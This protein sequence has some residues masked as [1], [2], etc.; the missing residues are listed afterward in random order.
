MRFWVDEIPLSPTAGNPVEE[1]RPNAPVMPWDVSRTP[2]TP[3]RRERG[4]SSHDAAERVRRECP[5]F[6]G[7]V[8]YH[9]NE[10]LQRERIPM[11]GT[12]NDRRERAFPTPKE[13]LP[14]RI[15][16]SRTPPEDQ[17]PRGCSL[18]SMEPLRE[19]FCKGADMTS[20]AEY[21]AALC[22]LED[23]P[24]D[25]RQYNVNIR[26]ERWTNFSL[27]GVRFPAM[28]VDVIQRGEA[29]AI[30]E[31]DLIIHFQQIS[32]AAALYI[33]A[34][35][36]GI[37]RALEVY[38]RVD[39]TTKNFPWSV[40]TTEEKW[41]SHA[42]GVL[43]VALTTLNLP[44]EAWK[45]ARLLRAVPNCRLVLMLAYHMLSPALSVEETGLMAYLQTPPEAGPSI[46][47]VT[48]GLQ[49]WKCAGRR[50][51]EIGGRL[52]TATQLHQSF[53]KIL[54]KH[55][56]ANKKVNFMFQ[57]Q[58]STIP[59]MNPSPTEIVELFSFVEVT[60]IQYATVAGHFPGVTAASVKPKPKKANKV[61]VTTDEPKGEPQ[62]NA[63]TPTT[64]RPKPKA[65]PKGNPQGTPAKVESKPSEAKKEGKGGGK[66]KR[67]K[68]EPRV[69]K[70]KQ[71]C[72]HFF[73]G[74]CQRGDQCRYEH[75]VG[76]DGRPVPVGPEILQR[77]DDA[78][79]RYNETRAQAQAKPKAAPRGGVSASMI[80]L[81]PDEVEHG[82]VLSA[83]QALDNDEYYAM[84][85]SGTNAIIVPLHPKMEGEV[86]ECQVPSATVTGPIVQVYEFEGTKRLVVAL[87]QSAILVSQEWLTTI[88]GWTFVSGPKPRLEGSVCENKVYPAGA[89]KSYVLSMKNGLPYLSKELFW[90]AMEDIARKATLISGHKWEELKEMIDN[91]NL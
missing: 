10:T 70:R 81:E 20:A 24:P 38:R 86:A 53:I 6:G 41:H 5:D 26:E 52:P 82:I 76:D 72:I 42:E 48:T 60:L 28:T 15:N 77:F 90:M 54:S 89:D 65:Q 27:E 34:L 80:I 3:D 55:L 62:I 39:D 7:G 79:K 29:L 85:D 44:T 43:M 14:P 87:P 83:A 49:N 17:N 50:L 59:V 67:G 16:Q 47:Q 91:R 12:S 68:S 69:E 88:A 66:G 9:E 61:E 51:V 30:F 78:V 36:G 37:K 71:Q 1:R 21:E 64:P 22:Q 31:R 40:P 8:D 74:T 13:R 63:T 46:V 33:R 45:S 25:I 57:Q 73:R 11:G 23:D 19:W 32:R 2:A 56:A 75:Q 84:L 18:H 4:T 58:S 35:L